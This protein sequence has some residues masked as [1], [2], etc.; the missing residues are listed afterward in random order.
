MSTLNSTKVPVEV[1][2]LM[3][4]AEKW[5]IGDDVYRVDAVEAASDD[6]LLQL[7][8]CLDGVEN[9]DALWDW[10]AGPEAQSP[11]PSTE[12]LA[13]TC[14]TMAMDTADSELKKRGLR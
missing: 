6:E 9:Q 11:T 7:V 13:Y 5:G 3:P 4:L 8:N 2:P 12:Y 14:L 10:L 1:V